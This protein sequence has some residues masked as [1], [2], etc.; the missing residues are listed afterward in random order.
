M[1]NRISVGIGIGAVVAALSWRGN[2][3]PHLGSDFLAL[4]RDS[5]RF[6]STRSASSSWFLP[7]GGGHCNIGWCCV[8][9]GQRGTWV[10]TFQPAVRRT[11]DI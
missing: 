11:I 7:S 10:R 5:L 8:W 2:T 4:C 1:A 9:R 3:A 6:P